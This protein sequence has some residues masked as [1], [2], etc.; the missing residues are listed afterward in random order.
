MKL[1]TIPKPDTST[2]RLRKTFDDALARLEDCD[3]M[4]VL[5][6]KKKG[7]I[8]WFAPAGSKIETAVWMASSFIHEVHNIMKEPKT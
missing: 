1:A 6:Q 5:M 3:E 2:E 7:G 4:V 8:L